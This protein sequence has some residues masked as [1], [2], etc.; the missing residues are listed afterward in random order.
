MTMIKT[1]G[2]RAGMLPMA[3]LAVL[4]AGCGTERA[5]ESAGAAGPSR[6]PVATPSTPVDFTCPG[7][8]PTSAPPTTAA[9]TGPAVPPTDHYAENH[10]FMVPFPLHGKQRCEGLQAVG[11]V[12]K[13]LEPL[14]KR[15]DFA[16]EN[17][18][19]ALTG[20]GYSAGQ[21]RSYQ[22]GSTGVG[23][24]IDAFPLC[25][26]GTMN[27]DSTK[28]DAF[29]GYPDHSGCDRPSGGH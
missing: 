13:A 3:V 29:G 26:E 11:R 1:A 23:F 9:T 18:R 15:G 8:S 24:L 14:R 12:E 19:T 5:G 4:A 16:P 17:T 10:G 27:R 2:I 28:A 20:L 7:E 21:V 25:V 22:N 6:T